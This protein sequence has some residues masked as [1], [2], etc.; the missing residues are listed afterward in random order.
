MIFDIRNKKIAVGALMIG[1]AF[2]VSACQ[3]DSAKKAAEAGAVAAPPP[4]GPD[5]LAAYCPSVNLRSGTAFYD[6]YAKGAKKKKSSDD[7]SDATDQTS[8]KGDNSDNIVYQAS[9]SQVTRDCRTANGTMTMTIAAA[10]KVVT[11]PQGKTGPVSL[12][13]RVAVLRGDQVLYSN[14][15]HYPVDI[16]NMAGATQFVYTA[17]NVS[18]AAPK[19]HDTLVYIG[20]D[21][22]PEKAVSKKRKKR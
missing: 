18:F 4:P 17:R 16:A 15:A 7:E 12:P 21:A 2:A 19:A 5:Q 13:I 6:V 11:G 1:L 8:D 22:G 10:G 14:L 20:F 3:S 9:I